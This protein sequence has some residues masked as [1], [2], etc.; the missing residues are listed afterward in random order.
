MIGTLRG[1]NVL[2][3]NVIWKLLD[4]GFEFLVIDVAGEKCGR[5]GV[6]GTGGWQ[7]IVIG[8]IRKMFL[9]HWGCR[10]YCQPVE[11]INK[12]FQNSKNVEFYV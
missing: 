2:G 4:V 10:L 8:V 7:E 12:K 11:K 1:T 6:G 3:E 5:R 9:E